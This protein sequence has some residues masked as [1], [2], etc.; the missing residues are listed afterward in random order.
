MFIKEDIRYTVPINYGHWI[1]C[2]PFL[3]SKTEIDICRNNPMVWQ[4]TVKEGIWSAVPDTVY[5]LH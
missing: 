5:P 2:P 3:E 1:S 4:G